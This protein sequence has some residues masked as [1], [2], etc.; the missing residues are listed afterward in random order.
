MK[1]ASLADKSRL[2]MLLA[3]ALLMLAASAAPAAESSIAPGTII[4]PANWRQYEA[5]MPEGFKELFS[6]R[7]VWKFPA[8]FKI[9]VG[10]AHHYPLPKV[11]LHNTEQHSRNVKIVTLPDGR[12]TLSGYVAGMPFPHPTPPD[13]GYKLLTDLWYAYNPYIVCDRH[14]SLYTEDRFGNVKLEKALAV[15][16]GLSGVSAS[17]QPITL[18]NAGGVRYAE[19]VQVLMPE[20]SKYLTNLTIQYTDELKPQDLFIFI[21]ALR[22]TLRLSTAARCAPFVGTDYTQDDVSQGGFNG[23][24]ALFNANYLGARQIL[25]L[26]QSDPRV[27]GNLNSYYPGLLWPRPAVGKWEVRTSNVIDIRRIP[28]WRKGYCYGKRICYLDSESFIPLWQDLYDA[29]MKL[30]KVNFFAQIAG[31]VPPDGITLWNGSFITGIYDLQNGHLT[32]NMTADASGGHNLA[33]DDCRN[34]EGTDYTDIGRYSS[35]S[36]LSQ[37]MR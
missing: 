27:Y 12:H 24:I 18:P 26:T 6:G 9:V 10:P 34:D 25:A 37:I 16:R 35:V 22:R 7:F 33:G 13:Q 32:L 17:D 11:Y 4:T 1:T 8:A 15:Y 30:W 23:G 19:Y 29:N 2:R 31:P 21:P 14:F 20:E 5:F 3:I 36:A 28:S